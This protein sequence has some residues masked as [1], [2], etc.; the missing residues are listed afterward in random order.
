MEYVG[1]ILGGFIFVSIVALVYTLATIR[2]TV[3]T[4]TGNIAENVEQ[5]LSIAAER[6]INI[7]TRLAAVEALLAKDI[8]TGGAVS[9]GVLMEEF[10]D[11]ISQSQA[12]DEDESND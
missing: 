7:E 11:V 3:E 9:D 4:S 12:T 1:L 10:Q 2:K 5:A 8:I 6:F